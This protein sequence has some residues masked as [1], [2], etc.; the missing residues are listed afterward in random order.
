MRSGDNIA[1]ISKRSHIL[2]AIAWL[3][4]ALI[5]VT[6]GVLGF[7]WLQQSRDNRDDLSLA[8]DNGALATPTVIENNN[9]FEPALNSIEQNQLSEDTVNWVNQTSV[10]AANDAVTKINI[11]S[12]NLNLGLSVGTND[13]LNGAVALADLAPE[14]LASLGVILENSVSSMHLADGAITT[15]DITN[16][17][18]TSQLLAMNAVDT[19][20]LADNA[21]TS[22]KLATGSVDGSKII[23]G[24]ISGNDLVNGAI[25]TL[26]L[27]NNAVTT[28][29]I[30]DDAI[31]SKMAASLRAI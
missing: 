18:I 15:L 20:A 12:V 5:V 28:A 2:G 22:L 30:N 31:T 6:L 13:I 4:L 8:A 3:L 19:A 17:A 1:A 24:S 23:N 16:G 25:S 11:G 29:I 26:Q 27:G 7:S 14:V 10:K 21:V 9:W